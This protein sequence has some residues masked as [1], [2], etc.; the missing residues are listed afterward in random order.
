[1]GK[2]PG[3]YPE[4]ANGCDFCTNTLAYAKSDHGFVQ[5]AYF[6][7]NLKYA[8]KLPKHMSCGYICTCLPC[9]NKIT[10][11]ANNVL[12]GKNIDLS[13]L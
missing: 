3:I 12:K 1:M 9:H 13:C 2:H 11:P 10:W 6:F 4:Y 5:H 7:T 8:N